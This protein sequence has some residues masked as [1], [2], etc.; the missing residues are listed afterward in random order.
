MED[1]TDF[2]W[3]GANAAHAVLLCGME[4]GRYSGITQIESTE[5]AGRMRKNK[6]GWDIQKT[7]SKNQNRW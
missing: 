5:F 7:I 6:L 1:A 3:Q 4:R 2:S